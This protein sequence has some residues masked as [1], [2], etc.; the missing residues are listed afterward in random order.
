MKSHILIFI[1]IIAFIVPNLFTQKQVDRSKTHVK[2]AT[3]AKLKLP[4]LVI[5]NIKIRMIKGKCK[6]EL[7]IENRGTAGVPAIRYGMV[8]DDSKASS[9]RVKIGSI[10]SVGRFLRK[11]DPNGKLK[12]PG[13]IVRHIW[14]IN[15]NFSTVPPGLH[16]ITAT[17]D[18]NSKVAELNEKNN[19]LTRR[20]TCNSRPILRPIKRKR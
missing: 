11:V 8:G 10:P 9:F 20:L 1:T 15:D 17:A 19:R 13:G 12:K 3:F 2:P 7:T 6:V 16:S 14:F 18:D 5:T 4:D